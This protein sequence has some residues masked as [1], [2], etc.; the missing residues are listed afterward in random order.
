MSVSTLKGVMRLHYDGRK[1]Y[2]Q[3]LDEAP[4]ATLD[5]VNGAG[6]PNKLI[7][8]E[9]LAVLRALLDGY[10]GKV[11]L[12]YID[13][14][15]A[16]NSHFRV[17][18]ERANSVSSSKLD[19]IAYSDRLVGPTYLEFLRERL[20]LLHELLSDSGS[21]YLHIDYKTGHYVKVLMDKIFGPENFRNDITRIKCNPKNFSRK[22]YDNIKDMILFYSKSGAGRW[23]EPR[24]PLSEEQE[25]RLFKKIDGNG[26]R[27]TTVPLHAPGETIKGDRKGVARVESA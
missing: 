9:N 14:P 20:A 25:T 17:G 27:Y 24:R 19:P 7:L 4:R 2:Q 12:V 10:A 26:R 11:G 21:I 8:G 16:T 13:P 1:T 6:A 22:G 15:F 23:Q 5:S 18:S 3:F